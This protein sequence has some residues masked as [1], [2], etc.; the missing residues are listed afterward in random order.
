[1]NDLVAM[2]TLL[3]VLLVQAKTA[4]SSTRRRRN[5]STPRK[6][7]HMTIENHR[8]KSPIARDHPAQGTKMQTRRHQHQTPQHTPKKTKTNPQKNA[9][10]DQKEPPN[11]R[12][13]TCILLRQLFYL[14]KF[15]ITLLLYWPQ[16]VKN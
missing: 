16:V 7:P 12:K 9:P 3:P 11:L 5:H 15:T 4:V 2:E 6:A 10:H 14:S 13:T 8:G 1:M